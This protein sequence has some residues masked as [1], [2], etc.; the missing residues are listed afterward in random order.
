MAQFLPFNGLLPTQDRAELVAAVPYDVVNSEEAA[1]LAKGNP[2]S[3]LHVSR[4]EI[5]LAPGIDLHSEEVYNQ[6]RAAFQ[7]L[8]KEAPLTLD[9][10]K[11]LYIYQ[12]QMNDHIQT[13]IIGA[14]SAEDYKNGV[15][16]KHEKTRQDK[17]DDRTRHVMEL[18]SHTGPAFFTYKDKAEI[19]SFVN[20]AMKEAPLFN[21]TAPDGIRHTLWRLD[22]SA[23][24][25]LSKYFDAVDVFYIA[26]GHHRSAA[27]AR[28]A[29]ECAPKNPNHT[30]K[31][32]Y[33][34][35]L[36]VAFPATQLAIMP[37]N[38]AVKNL[39]GHSKDEFMKLI[40]EKFAVTPSADG[41]AAKQGEFKMYIDHAWYNVAPKFDITKLGVIESLDVSVLQDNIL[42]PILGIADPRTSQDIDFIGGIRGTAELEK[43]VNSGS[44]EV[45]FSMFATTVDQLMAIADAGEIMPPKSTWFEPKLRDGLVSHN[46]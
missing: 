5:D 20:N 29:A 18:R 22:E 32:D 19:D 40:S 42:A 36:A 3:F 24:S 6:A 10:G 37:Y 41:K 46:F 9:E 7:K 12:L 26:D 30:G 14:A 15:I 23:S 13:G 11:H 25:Q 2:Y 33:N 16:K 43:L 27:A 28:T 38:R 17:E 35:F 44:H 45:A 8:C 4:P 34:Y 39:N 21:F 1:E 31:E